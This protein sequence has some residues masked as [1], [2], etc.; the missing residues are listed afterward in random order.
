M[1][2]IKQ[3][4]SSARRIR[5]KIASFALIIL[6]IGIPIIAYIISNARSADAAWWNDNWTYRASI[7]IS[8]HTALETN[9]YLNLTGTDDLDTSDTTKFQADCGDL[10]FT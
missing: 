9:V 1:N 10:R 4:I 6:V 2:K 8:A 7:N 3:F 5:R